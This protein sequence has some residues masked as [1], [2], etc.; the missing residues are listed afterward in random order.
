MKSTHLKGEE[1][2]KQRY[3][4]A[5]IHR[6][7]GHVV[8]LR[9]PREVP[10]A[11]EVLEYETYYEPRRVVDTRGRRYIADAIEENGSADEFDP[12]AWVSPLP[13][14]KWYGQYS[15]HC[16][17]IELGVIQRMCPELFT[18]PDKTPAKKVE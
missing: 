13:K 10:L 2:Q 9:P 11:D 4:S 14:P 12:R 1:Y 6:G 16:K 5:T 8:E 3:Y 7:T 17:S 18:G 15:S